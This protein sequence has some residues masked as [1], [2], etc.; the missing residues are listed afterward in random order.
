VLTRPRHPFVMTSLCGALT[1]SAS[2]ACTGAIDDGNG[3][4][5]GEP[6]PGGR[7]QPTPPS[8][9]GFGPGAVVESAGPQQ[10]RRLTI[11][12]YNNT[13]R[14]LLGDGTAPARE[15]T[16]SVDLP[17]AVGFVSGARITT[18]VDASQFLDLS[19]KLSEGAAQRLAMLLPQ[20]CAA[21]A[22]NAEEGC[23]RQFI[24]QFG[25][26]AFRRPLVAEEEADLQALYEKQRTPEVGATFPEAIRTLIAGILQS[27]FFL[28]RWELAEAPQKDGSLYRLNSY[29]MASRLSYFLWATM[30]DTKLFEA[31]SRNELQ[32]PARIAQEAR[33]MMSDPKFKDM[34]RDFTL[35]WLAV[36]GLPSMEKD[37]SFENYTPEVGQA[38][39]AETSEFVTGL[40]YGPEAT[41]KLDE[42]FTSRTSFLDAKLAKVYGV[43]GVTGDTL[44]RAT[45]NPEQRAGILTQGAFLASHSDADFT[46]P[47]KRGVHIL[48]AVLCRDIP[49]PDD[50]MVPPL[51]ERL[52]NQTTRERFETFTKGGVCEA[53]HSQINPIGFAFES[54][55]TV[56]EFRTTEEGKPVDPSGTVTLSTGPV[57]FKNAVELS[58]ALSTAQEVRDCMTRQWLRYVVRRSEVKE[59]E[60]SLKNLLDAFARSGYDMRELLVDTTKTRAFTHRQPLEGE[61]QK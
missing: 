36:A 4:P 35:Q 20:G 53:C 56:G 59:E 18:S 47:V 14:D 16:L 11:A 24:K 27:P 10:L 57:T 50:I 15:G 42:L 22:A 30:P 21:P 60:A 54:Y 5:E 46:H 52:P 39:L 12:E 43:G 37:G 40:L 3:D 23:A 31:A 41:G 45:L 61:G 49:P 28:Y 58:Q 2:L 25:L 51:P 8:E 19:Q 48:H 38:M 55:N 29:E 9:P 7:V 6:P 13:V 34:I 44:Q 17:T 32:A 33:R 26:R 1:L